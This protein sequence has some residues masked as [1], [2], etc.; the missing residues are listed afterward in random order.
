M[1]GI[2]RRTWL[3]QA[4]KGNMAEETINITISTEK[5]R[6]IASSDWPQG[7]LLFMKYSLVACFGITLN[8]ERT[9]TRGPS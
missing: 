1:F 4:I 7:E 3:E 6:K 2:N 5:K 8:L 9:P